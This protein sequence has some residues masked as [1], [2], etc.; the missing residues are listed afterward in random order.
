[1]ITSPP[2][3]SAPAHL[4]DLLDRRNGVGRRRVVL[5]GSRRG[6]ASVVNKGRLVD[7]PEECPG[8][9]DEARL[10][11]RQGVIG[12]A[13]VSIETC[14]MRLALGASSA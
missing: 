2:L 10:V 3:P 8:H 11:E 7:S 9:P 4:V 6:V 14:H 13:I 5:S 12:R 1:V